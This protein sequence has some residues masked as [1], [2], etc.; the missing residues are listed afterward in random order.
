MTAFV[1]FMVRHPRD[2]DLLIYPTELEERYV[3]T[4][5]FYVLGLSDDEL[6]DAYVF[7]A[8]YNDQIEPILLTRVTPTRTIYRAVFPPV[9]IFDFWAYRTRGWEARVGGNNH[10]SGVPMLRQ[11]R[12][13]RADV[14]D[15]AARQH[16]FYFIGYSPRLDNAVPDL[17]M[18]PG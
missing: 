10:F 4:G 16:R 15:V 7:F 13:K 14:L 1:H 2:R 5:A 8:I 9:G 11:I 12:P 17:S 3:G 18:K 6:M